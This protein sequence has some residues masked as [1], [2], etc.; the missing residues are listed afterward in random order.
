[1]EDKAVKGLPGFDGFAVG[2]NYWASHAGISMWR[3]FDASEVEA[4]FAALRENGVN[5]VRLF[6]L[7]PDFQ[8]VSWAY[9]QAGCPVELVFPDGSPLPRK[10]LRSYGLDPEMMARFRIVADLAAKYELKLVVGLLTGWMSGALFVPPALAGRNVGSDYFAHRLQKM[11]VTGFVTEMRDHPAI[12]AWEP[13]NECNCMAKF[14]RDSSWSWLDLVVSAIRLA[15]PSR[16]VYA[17]MH[18]GGNRTDRPVPLTDQGELCDVLTTHPY[19]AFTPHC[20][21]SALNTI[22]AVF[23]APAETLFYRGVSGKAAFVEEIGSFGPGY[24]SDERSEKY[25]YTMLYSAFVHGFGGMM[26]WCGFSFD[27][28]AGQYPYR[29]TAMERELGAFGSGRAPA[30]PARAMKRF[31]SELAQLPELPERE[32]DAVAVLTDLEDA[33]L[34]AYGTYILSTEAGFGIEFCDLASVDE[35]PESGFYIVPAV[36]GFNSMALAKYRMLLDRAEA[37]AT[38]MVTLGD[39]ILSNFAEVFGCAVEFSANTPERLEFSVDGENY[40]FDAAITRRLTA[41]DGEVVARLADGTPF[42]VRRKFGRGQVI[43]VNAAL[44]NG[45]LVPGNGFC[46]VYRKLARLAGVVLPDK[47]PSVG[48]TRHILPD[49]RELKFYINYADTPADG[50]PGNSVRY[51]LS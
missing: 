11:F 37:G 12:A 42:A 26:W 40:T 38:V 1:M 22:P 13:G 9:G 5:A 3:N 2:V 45:A 7:W 6:P 28:C 29:W 19:P 30:G 18:G 10:G 36:S 50:M 34:T 49:G 51:E 16:P 24:I 15:D 48:V 41:L 14:D 25:C 33:W 32:I 35:L 47:S 46:R 27:R 39:A 23:H 8:P 4:D 31:A 43:C 17:G 21:K 20:G 44:E